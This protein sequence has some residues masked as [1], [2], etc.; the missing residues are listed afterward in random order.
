ML[1]YWHVVAVND[2]SIEAPGLNAV[3]ET[4]LNAAET[5]SIAGKVVP[6]PAIY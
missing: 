6:T 3:V 2:G 4:A 1:L 5:S